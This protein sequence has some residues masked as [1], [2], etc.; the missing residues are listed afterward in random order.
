MSAAVWAPLS[1]V[2]VAIATAKHLT[3]QPRDRAEPW[4]CFQSTYTLACLPHRVSSS[5]EGALMRPCKNSPPPS[6][7]GCHDPRP[8]GLNEL[9]S[10][11]PPEHHLRQ[12]TP[13][14]AKGV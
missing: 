12:E 3:F 7:V 11:V 9:L 4:I 5:L 8:D 13:Y 2:G 6:S 14:M 1:M 10:W